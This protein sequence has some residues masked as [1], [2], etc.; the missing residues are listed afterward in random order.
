[1]IVTV[2]QVKLGAANYI[3]QEV[4]KRA[5]G[6]KKCLYWIASEL[7]PEYVQYWVDKAYSDPVMLKKFFDESGNVRLDEVYG[8]A[9]RS[10][11]NSGQ[12]LAFGL[13]FNETDVDRLYSYIKSTTI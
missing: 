7:A 4:W 1:M 12:F 5:T 6:F 10:V 13:I 9:K 2:E 3:S 11:E 8:L